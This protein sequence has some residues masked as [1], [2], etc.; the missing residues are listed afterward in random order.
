MQLFQFFIATKT[1]PR[2]TYCDICSILKTGEFLLPALS[3]SNNYHESV[4]LSLLNADNHSEFEDPICYRSFRK[5]WNQNRTF[6]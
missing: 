4:L 1:C 2:I 3:K 5:R 6:V